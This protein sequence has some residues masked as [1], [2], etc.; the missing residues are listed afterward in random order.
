MENNK[1]YFSDSLP[2]KPNENNETN[3]GGAPLLWIII[4][5]ACGI[6]VIICVIIVIICITKGKANDLTDDVKKISFMDQNK[7][8]EWEGS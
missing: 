7:R 8:E 2:N 3:K 4:I 5:S 6:S 1:V